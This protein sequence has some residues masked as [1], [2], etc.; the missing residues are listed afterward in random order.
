MRQSGIVALTT[1]LACGTPE[2]PRLARALTDEYSQG[3]PWGRVGV[4]LPCRSDTLIVDESP[5]GQWV[6]RWARAP[7]PPPYVP[8]PVKICTDTAAIQLVFYRDSLIA[9]AMPVPISTPDTS[10]D[11]MWHAWGKAFAIR[12]LGEPDSVI[13]G[14]E[15]DRWVYVESA[16]TLQAFWNREQGRGWYGYLFMVSAIPP[17][18]LGT[19]FAAYT[20]FGAWVALCGKV[21][22]ELCRFWTRNAI[23]VG[24]DFRGRVEFGH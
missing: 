5:G 19:E 16:S 6:P 13:S 10:V 20:R 22:D 18:G 12:S 24:P 1:L 8:H 21:S 7:S 3:E 15:V 14:R 2:R 17:A 4:A 11:A 23:W 9:V